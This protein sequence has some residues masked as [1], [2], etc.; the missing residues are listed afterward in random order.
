MLYTDNW[1]TSSD[2]ACKLLYKITHLVGTLHVNRRGNS[3]EVM[4]KKLKRGEITVKNNKKEITIL[5]WRDKRD[6][7]LLSI[8]QLSEMVNIEKQSGHCLKPKIVVA[9]NV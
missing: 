5:K 8:K 7:L 1:Y 9:Y 3:H 6:I 2:L 4:S